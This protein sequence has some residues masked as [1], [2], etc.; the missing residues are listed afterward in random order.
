MENFQAVAS[1]ILMI[2]VYS[3]IENI[4][5]ALKEN[6]FFQGKLFYIFLL[7]ATIGMFTVRKAQYDSP[8]YI[9]GYV[10]PFFMEYILGKKRNEVNS[11]KFKMVL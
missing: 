5:K 4:T 10:H 2:Q 6:T 11:Q 7:V 9:F 1:Q 8:A 3:N